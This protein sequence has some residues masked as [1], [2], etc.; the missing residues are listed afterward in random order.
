M[1]GSGLKTVIDFEWH[2]YSILV[3]NDPA[4]FLTVDK[5]QQVGIDDALLAQEALSNHIR[6]AQWQVETWHTQRSHS[7]QTQRPATKA[8]EEKGE[9]KHPDANTFN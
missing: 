7:T 6:V 9:S 1:K 2:L 8:S 3:S 5:S 4:I